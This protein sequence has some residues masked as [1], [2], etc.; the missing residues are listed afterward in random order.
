MRERRRVERP[1]ERE[2]AGLELAP[3]RFDQRAMLVKRPAIVPQAGAGLAVGVDRALS[4]RE[5]GAVA[6]VHVALS[7][8]AAGEQHVVAV[9]FDMPVG[10]GLNIDLRHR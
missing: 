8:Q 7:G 6:D 1:A 3:H 10:D 9:E 2:G 4:S 5:E